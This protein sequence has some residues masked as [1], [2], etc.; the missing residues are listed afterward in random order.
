[1]S[2]AKN[3]SKVGYGNPPKHRQF[4]KGKSGNPTGRPKAS[5][6]LK[7]VHRIVRDFLE[8]EI[9]VVSNG[10]KKSITMLE[11]ALQRLAKAALEDGNTQAIKLMLTMAE[12]HIPIRPSLTELMNNRSVFEFTAEEAERYSKTNLLEGMSG[13]S[14]APDL[15]SGCPVQDEAPE[16]DVS[17]PSGTS[18]HNDDKRIL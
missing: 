7:S 6:Q 5:R 4:Q 9:V 16:D 10:R 17:S 8:Q 13:L 18:P 2:S 12:E 15:A 3:G 1:M 11:A 14:R